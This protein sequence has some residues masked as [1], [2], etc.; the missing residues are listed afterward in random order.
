[1]TL[2]ASILALTLGLAP[3]ALQAQEILRVP[4]DK[5]VGDA[6]DAFAAAIEP[7]GIT[8]FARI[9]HG[10]GAQM[11]GSDIG[12]SELLVFG[13]PMVG[14]PAIEANRLAALMLPLT[15]L[16]YEDTEG[17]VWLAY[18]DPADRLTGFDGIAAD[19]DF[20]ATMTGAMANFTGRAAQ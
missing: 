7:A 15:V 3:L 2:R 11:V 10:M 17:Q 19:A 5:T 18:Q 14:T 9:D 12:A 8:L 13:N 4:T 16:V 1:M 20:I 6:A